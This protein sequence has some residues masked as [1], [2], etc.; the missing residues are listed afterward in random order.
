MSRKHGKK[1][2]FSKYTT[3]LQ[4]NSTEWSIGLSLV[5][6][7]ST[8]IE[9]SIH[10]QKTWH[11]MYWY[12][13]GVLIL[14]SLSK[15]IADSET[16]GKVCLLCIIHGW[17]LTYRHPLCSKIICKARR[18][19]VKQFHGDTN[20]ASC[21]TVAAASYEIQWHFF[22]SDIYCKWSHLQQVGFCSCYP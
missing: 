7:V 4:P 18:L 14:S 13:A 8:V 21:L 19:L 5:I 20:A 10:P 11:C 3:N 2:Q 16:S 17:R 22:L 15:D 6:T 12:I 1:C 9:V